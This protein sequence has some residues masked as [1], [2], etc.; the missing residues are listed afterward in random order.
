[1]LVAG[2]WIVCA[3]DRAAAFTLWVAFGGAGGGACRLGLALVAGRCCGGADAVEA[4]A[5][6]D[7]AVELV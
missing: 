7:V 5:G 3:S 1:M 2:R 4:M 6:R